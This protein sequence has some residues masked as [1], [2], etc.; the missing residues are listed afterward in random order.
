MALRIGD[1]LVEKKIITSEELDSAI[2]EHR[3]TK[4]FLGQTLVRLGFVSEK[5]LLEVLAEQQG[6]MFVE[7]KN[8]KIDKKV[9]T[10]VPAKFVWHYKIMPIN[11]EG[12]VLTVA[13]SNPFDVWPLDD[14]EINLGYR[15]ESVL[16]VSSDIMNAIGKYYG[17]GSDTIEEILSQDAEKKEQK[18]QIKEEK[19]EDLEKMAK[20]ASVVKLVNQILQ[21][22]INDRATDIHIER[23]RNEIDLRYRIDGILYS[24]Q[25]SENI[26]YLYSAIISRVKIM[27][28]LDIIERRLP[29]DGRSR[30]KIGKKDYDLRISVMPTLYGENVVIRILPTSMLYSIA[31][32][33]MS[34]DDTK[35]LERI[36]KKPNGIIFVTGPTGSGK[37]TTLYACLSYLNSRERKIVAIEDPIE[38]EL[39][40]ISQ[41]QVNPRIDL[42]FARAL[43]SVLRHD[44]DV[45]M[46]GEVRD[47]ET[48]EIT[49]Q[50]ALTGHLV[51]STL[52]TNDAAGGATRLVDM[53]VK[54]FLIASSVEV[55]IAQRLVRKI[56]EHCKERVSIKDE[57]LK[58]EEFFRDK[59]VNFYRGKG[60]KL[61][62]NT[63]YFGRT[64]IYEALVMS[65]SMKALVLEKTSSNIIK[66]K[67]VEFG[68]KTLKQ[69][70]FEKVLAGI[71]SFEEIMRVT[72]EEK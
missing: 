53:G 55:F 58:N 18:A 34:K 54:P 72:Q 61:C 19:V 15:V 59:K 50:T 66:K 46:V 14:L 33:G 23:F 25:V 42:T 10:S 32:L 68:M 3:G 63:G 24:A 11:I 22:A 21:Q 38:Y 31:D 51:F 41:I 64:S 13:A 47:F 45:I 2:K 20:D 60:C 7:L 69:D 1:I 12:D 35:N 26:R 62:N 67:A 40:G 4:E 36:L 39:K 57:K 49:I 5:K 27:S 9:I 8:I 29:Q 16:A 70:G 28:G 48:A 17:V 43:R 30:V 6:L 65:E 37:S 71:T 44:P 52:H 56:C